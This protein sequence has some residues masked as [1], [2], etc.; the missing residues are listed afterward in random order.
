MWVTRNFDKTT[1]F[2]SLQTL[3]NK[4]DR[5]GGGI[6]SFDLNSHM[7]FG[8]KF[9]DRSVHSWVQFW[10]FQNIWYDHRHNVIVVLSH[11][12]FTFR[13][14]F[15]SFFFLIRLKAKFYRMTN[16]NGYI[17]GAIRERCTNLQSPK[18]KQKME[19]YQSCIA[20]LTHRPNGQKFTSLKKTYIS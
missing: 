9:I 11:T 13:F 15:G 2:Q 20:N 12:T 14:I 19:N 6:W 8:W 7:E 3:L 10:T 17:R 4:T 5:G 1:E 16:H 18:R